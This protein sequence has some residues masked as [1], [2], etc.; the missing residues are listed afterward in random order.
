MAI[1]TAR[2]APPEEFPARVLTTAGS[3]AVTVPPLPARILTLLARPGDSVAR[4]GAIARVIMP[5]ADAAVAT[6]RAVDA[7][8]AV[9]TRRRARLGSLETEGLVRAS[10]LATL[11]LD[12]ARLT[13]EKLRA[14]AVL[15]GAGLTTGGTI[16][17]RSPVAGV[18]TEVAATVGELRRPEDGPIARVRS[19]GGRRIEASVPTIPTPDATYTF[20]SGGAAPVAVVLVNAV[21][22]TP[23]VGYLAWF[24][25]PE[26]L[27]AP[28][29]PEGRLAT[30]ASA[31]PDAY[32]VPAGAVGLRGQARFIVVRSRTADAPTV[33]TVEVVRI[34]SSDAVVRGNV[35][36]GALVASDPYR[37]RTE[38]GGSGP[39][40]RP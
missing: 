30:R 32:L 1:R 6:I 38:A 21:P 3:T 31:S 11:D 16:T 4:D 33:V 24:D 17:L 36:S 25:V 35:P 8:L 12:V 40:G 37:A 23:G 39:D 22:R 15:G 7:S 2:D 20:Q 10:E 19:H 27:P 9:L 26:G 18:V 5:E 14:A 13:G 34:A 29:S 28:V